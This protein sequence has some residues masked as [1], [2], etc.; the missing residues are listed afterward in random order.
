VTNAPLDLD[1]PRWERAET[2]ISRVF[3]TSDEAYKLKKPVELGFLDFRSLDQRRSACEAEVRLNARLAPDV[4]RGV[5]PVRKGADGRLR[6][7]H[8]VKGELADWAV[9]M[10]RLSDARRADRLL[11]SGALGG[12]DVDAV[13]ACLARFHASAPAAVQGPDVVLRNIEE[14]FAQTKDG[15]FRYVAPAEAE[16][17]AGW[18]RAFFADHRRI[19]EERERTGRVRDGHGDLR[20]E[21][22]YFEDGRITVLDC[23][24]FNE[25]F[26][27]GDVCSDVAFLSMDLAWH[28][29]VHL[30][31]RLLA[32]YAR[33]SNDFDLY[34]LVDFY[35]GYRAYVRGKICHFLANDAGAPLGVREHAAH[36]ARRYFLLALSAD[37][38]ALLG[39]SVVAVGGTIASGKSTVA[40]EIGA[41][42]SAPVIC[43]DRTRKFMLGVGATERLPEAP[44][45]GAYDPELTV[46]V[47]A[48]VLRR[49]RVVLD[50]G[51]PVVLDASFR[52][53][54]M[55]AMAR[56]LAEERGV[57]FWFVECRASEDACRVRLRERERQE[58]VSDGRLAIFDAF[59]AHFEPV[60][61][62]AKEAHIVVDTTRPLGETR[63][64][65]A[66]RLDSWPPGLVA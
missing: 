10:R 2:H 41:A 32:S 25:R 56:E 51:R 64:L 58:S 37:R 16:E 5:V 18:Q 26:R 33:E 39:P 13:A 24:E 45:S 63:R 34:T 6:A 35:E 53:A 31:E 38:R 42:T 1:D 40:R 14:N 20:L 21:H 27:V 4:Y 61:E 62:I 47:Y 29:A 19:F 59:S 52:S 44:W 23:I 11:E 65:L 57:P 60:T 3:L 36:Q 9:V 15:I 50:S 66:A 12:E 46:R 22:V 49:A 17:I 30:A 48:E 28:G 55:R 43:A 8:G 7:G 54:G